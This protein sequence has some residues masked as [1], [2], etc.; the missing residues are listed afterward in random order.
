MKAIIGAMLIGLGHAATA[1]AQ[2]PVGMPA[3]EA[4]ETAGGA[5]F[6]GSNPTPAPTGVH[7]SGVTGQPPPLLSLPPAVAPVTLSGPGTPAPV[8]AEIAIPP[9][10]YA[11]GSPVITRPSL[12]IPQPIA[13]PKVNLSADGTAQTLPTPEPVLPVSPPTSVNEPYEN[14]TPSLPAIPEP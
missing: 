6:F 11:A 9:S 12:P 2:P 7:F 13:V 4:K 1:F 5:R 8:P 10:T 3:S 14:F